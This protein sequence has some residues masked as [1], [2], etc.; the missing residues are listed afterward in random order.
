[1]DS[2][3][4][5]HNRSTWQRYVEFAMHL[6]RVEKIDPK[7]FLAGVKVWFSAVKFPSSCHL[8]AITDTA[9]PFKLAALPA[10]RN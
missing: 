7:S 8:C 5:A 10:I 9:V 3:P 6:E 4:P 2:Q 1:M